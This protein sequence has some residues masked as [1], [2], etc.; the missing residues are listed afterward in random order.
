MTKTRIDRGDNVAGKW[1]ALVPGIPDKH[2]IRGKVPMT[3]EEVRAITL[4]KLRVKPD[5]TVVDIGAGTGSV[6][7]EAAITAKLG[8]VI[9]IERNSEGVDLIKAN[10]EAFELDNIEVIEGLAPDNLPSGIQVDKVF[11][12]GTGGWMDDAIEWAHRNLRPD[13]RLVI[14]TVTIENTYKALENLKRMAFDEL[15]VIQVQ[16]SRGE[17]FHSITMMK[18]NNPIT[19]ISAKKR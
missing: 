1:D 10:A 7:I 16:I 12:G 6:S 11:I 14:N 2:F 3:K 19:I 8:K 18:S 15:E 9:S 13:G 5:D 4:S 17:F